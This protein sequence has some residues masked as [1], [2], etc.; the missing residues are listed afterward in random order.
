MAYCAAG[1]ESEK[2]SFMRLCFS[3]G[4]LFVASLFAGA[5][6]MG[7]LIKAIAFGSIDSHTYYFGRSMSDALEDRAGDDT[8]APSA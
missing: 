6:A 7:A 2:T 5:A 3:P 1:S 8:G 4:T